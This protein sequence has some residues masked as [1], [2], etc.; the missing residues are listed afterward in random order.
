M[1][2]PWV[3]GMRRAWVRHR[4]TDPTFAFVAEP[5]PDDEWVAID[6]ETTG[7][8]VDRDRIVSIEAV[9]IA[10]NRLLTSERLE[11][12]VRPDRTIP[13]DA[14]GP[15]PG[16]RD[17]GKGM[18]A[19]LAMRRLLAHIGSRPLVGY[20]LAF[21][22]AMLD[23]EIQPLLGIGLPQSRIEV[24]ALYYEYRNRQ[25]PPQERGGRID[26]RFATLMADLGLPMGTR[27]ASFGPAVMAG[28]AFLKLRRL[29][30]DG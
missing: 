2:V 24:S 10:G 25:L 13:D 22:V 29:L 14:V 9:R 6:C 12:I 16:E 3:D 23:R 1:S 26:L 18:P 17:G 7:F 4:L 27:S 28:L 5:P 30:R 15:P 11:L 20:Y 8:D 21:D 19:A